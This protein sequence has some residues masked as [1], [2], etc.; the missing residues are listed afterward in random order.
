MPF[1]PM[2]KEEATEFLKRIG[3]KKRRVLTGTEREHMLLVFALIEPTESSNNQRTFTE[4]YH[5]AGK[6][7]ELT[8]GFSDDGN[9]DPWVEEVTEL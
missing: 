5:H 7:Y 1:P 3:Y 8:W 6:D 9:P 4:T 2:T